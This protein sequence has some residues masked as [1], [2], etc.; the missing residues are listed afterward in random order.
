MKKARR[1]FLRLVASTGALVLLPSIA[2]AQKYPARPVRILVG[3]AAGG[4]A[5]TLARIVGQALGKS[6]ASLHSRE[7]RGSW[8]QPRNGNNSAISGRWLFDLYQYNA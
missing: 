3:Y 7:S 6:G 5:D 8:W 4:A 2:R 1:E